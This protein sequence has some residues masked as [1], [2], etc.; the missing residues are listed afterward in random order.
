MQDQSKTTHFGLMRHAQT[1]WNREKKIQGRSDSPLTAEGEKQALSWGLALSQFPWRRILASDAGRARATAEIINTI[2]KVPL[3]IDSRLKEQDWGQWEAK[4]VRQIQAEA[5][6][7]LDAQVN[8]GWDFCPPGGES[9]RRVWKRSQQAL[10]QAAERFAGQ[11]ILVVTHEGIVKSLIYHL[12]GRKF[13]PEEPA[14]LKSYQ[15]HRLICDGNGLQIEAINAIAL[16][17]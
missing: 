15:L 9:R 10:V 1:I 12:C 6:Q 11:H 13:L 7:V 4:T 3:T 5:R 16:D 14:I 17:S 2:L 8:A